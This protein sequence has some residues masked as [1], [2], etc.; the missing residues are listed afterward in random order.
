[1][2]LL[3]G[4][5]NPGPSYSQNRHNVGFMAAD[6]V[7][8]HYSFAPFR[9]KFQGLCCDG[10][11]DGHRLLILKPQTYMNASGRSVADA[12]KF[13]K[14]APEEII[15]FHDDIDLKPGKI[16]AKLGGGAGGHNGLRSIDDYVGSDYWRVRIGVGRPAA[17]GV[18]EDYVLQNFARA[19]GLWL[20]PALAAVAEALPLLLD[21]DAPGFMTK[22]ARL[23][24]PP[25]PG[26][27]AG[28][29][30]PDG[31]DGI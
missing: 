27:K 5:G 9:K 1:M 11:A 13:Y 26:G 20:K 28:E 3:V 6:A 8:G 16:R 24:P 30:G 19:D 17:S 10:T 31:D 23:A 14:V 29:S 4:L 22:V 18:V 12:V 25:A 15:V 21:G 7:A 2:Q